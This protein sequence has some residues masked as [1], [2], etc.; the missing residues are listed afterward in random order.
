MIQQPDD[1][2]YRLVANRL[3]AGAVVPFLG[4]GVGL[5]GRPAEVPWELGRYLP[6]GKELAEYLARDIDY[7]AGEP[8]DLLR[9][10]QYVDVKLGNGPLYEAL[11]AVFDADY[12]PTPIHRLLASLPERIRTVRGEG[13]RFFPLYVTTNYDSLLEQAL[14]DAGEEYDL[15]TYMAEGP[16]KNRFVHTRPVRR[17]DAHHRRQQL[18]RAALRSTAGGRQ[19]P[20]CSRTPD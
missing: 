18:S 16:D 17:G 7:P 11:H 20:R 10:C 5:C 14:R 19:D 4:A 8:F 2:H 3:M 15:V 6:S 9:V 12:A 13:P 1:E